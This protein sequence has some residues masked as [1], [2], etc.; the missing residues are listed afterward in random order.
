[1]GLP[2]REHTGNAKGR[3][4]GLSLFGCARREEKAAAAGANIELGNGRD[5]GGIHTGKDV[6]CM[7]YNRGVCALCT[8]LL[9]I[10]LLFVSGGS[11]AEAVTGVLEKPA[12]REYIVDTAGMVTVEDRQRI[13]KIGE[14]LRT[15]TKAESSLP[16]I[17]SRAGTSRPMPTNFF[18]DGDLV[19]RSSIT[20]SFFSSSRRIENSA[21]R[22]VT[23][24]RAR[25]RTADRGK[26]SME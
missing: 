5:E 23:A 3:R 11:F 10:A 21:L 7:K 18:G 24:L 26:S 14:D 22:S 8:L 6:A 12:Q 13:T 25:S 4:S 16:L 2:C 15:Q 9:M 19:M 20:A 1:M 17:H